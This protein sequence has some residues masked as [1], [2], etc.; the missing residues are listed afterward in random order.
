MS[1]CLRTY[2][3]QKIRVHLLQIEPGQSPGQSPDQS[4]GQSRGQSPGQ[5]LGQSPGQSNS[6]S[7][8]TFLGTGNVRWVPAYL[9]RYE[10]HIFGKS[11]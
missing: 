9:E 5:S 10:F 1:E 11:F 3:P 8:G 2:G 6:Q 4:R 7:P